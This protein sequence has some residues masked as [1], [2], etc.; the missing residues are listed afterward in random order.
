MNDTFD[1]DKFACNL[2]AYRCDKPSILSYHNNRK[3][4]TLRKYTVY[5]VGLFMQGETI[6]RSTG[7]NVKKL[8]KLLINKY[9]YTY[10]STSVSESK[11]YFIIY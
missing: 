11:V 4:L 9:R 5:L 8:K 1:T 10:G 7:K 6:M 2:C 3:Y